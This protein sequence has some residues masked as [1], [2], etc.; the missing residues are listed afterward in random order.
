M[1]LFKKKEKKKTAK[2][3]LK[4]NF[5]KE[6]DIT[7]LIEEFLKDEWSYK[8]NNTEKREK[9]EALQYKDLNK[10]VKSYFEIYDGPLNMISCLAEEE[11]LNFD[12]DFSVE[13]EVLE[14]EK[15]QEAC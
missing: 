2:L 13:V 14:N 9:W 10:L 6:I 4:V 3:Q 5:N 1:E 15:I 11:T 7:E 8:H 12:E